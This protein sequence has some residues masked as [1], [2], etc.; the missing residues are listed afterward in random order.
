MMT[1]AEIR[2]IWNALTVSSLRRQY[3][4]ARPPACVTL[5]RKWADDPRKDLRFERTSRSVTKYIA[6][7]TARARLDY[8]DIPLSDA[9]LLASIREDI[10]TLET[11][12]N[13]AVIA[14]SPLSSSLTDIRS[15]E[16]LAIIA[17][18]SE[19]IQQRI[20]NIE[21]KGDFAE[22]YF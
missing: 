5:S 17:S 8:N 13:A 11:C 16:G 21:K 14:Q 22:R 12:G 1:T 19:S 20:A 3:H 7:L 2:R 18:L 9:L 6:V 10:D 4:T 15:T